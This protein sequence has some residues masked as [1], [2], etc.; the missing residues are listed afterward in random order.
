V[1][2]NVVTEGARIDDRREVAPE[3]EPAPSSRSI[4]VPDRGRLQDGVQLAATE[5]LFVRE[6]RRE[7]IFGTDEL[8]GLIGRAAHAVGEAHPGPSLSVG[9]LSR[10]RGGLLHPHRSHRSGRDADLGFYLLDEEGHP[11]QAPR[12][13]SLRRDGCGRIGE[14]RY[15]FDPVRSWALIAA[16]VSDPSAR[17]QYVLVAPD[18][19]RRL[20]A[21]GERIG[22]PQEL[23]DRVS[24]VTEP[25]SGS[26][27]HR[28][29]FHVRIYCPV[30]DRPECI[31]E[32][33]F[34]DWYEGE[35]APPT[36]TI[37]RIRTTQRR[38]AR[39]RAERARVRA[40]ART[41]ARRTARAS[42]RRARRSRAAPASSP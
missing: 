40:A 3:P 5:D 32:P 15:C 12:F 18:I 8:V 28:S 31:D 34:Y 21:E 37:R 13:V 23:R 38:A 17:V 35:P 24:T 7:A 9:D 22:A 33:P 4:G 20:L 25:H 16:A 30:G 41:T 36:P 26:H 29:H 10:A 14:Q 1:L 42:A 2:A 6:T 27:A 19:R 11:I 39:R